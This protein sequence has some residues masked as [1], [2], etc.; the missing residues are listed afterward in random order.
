MAV[1]C[2]CLQVAAA[3]E[4]IDSGIYRFLGTIDDE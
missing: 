4:W 3:G 1:Q 2:V